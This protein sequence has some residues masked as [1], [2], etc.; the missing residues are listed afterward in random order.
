V[1]VVELAAVALL[2]FGSGMLFQR[3]QWRAT[4]VAAPSLALSRPAPGAAVAPLPPP[5][6]PAPPAAPAPAPPVPAVPTVTTPTFVVQAAVK[7][8]PKKRILR[9]RAAP[10]PTYARR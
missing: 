9:R 6:I 5:S 4:Q 1:R 10:R 8:T 3:A 7:K 2:A